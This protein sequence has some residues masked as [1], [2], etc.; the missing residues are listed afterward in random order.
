MSP[1][2]PS[3]TTFTTTVPLEH[4]NKVVLVGPAENLEPLQV[5]DVRLLVLSERY[6]P[7]KGERYLPLLDIQKMN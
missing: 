2:T 4:L 1:R 6:G 5:A 7:L 3:S